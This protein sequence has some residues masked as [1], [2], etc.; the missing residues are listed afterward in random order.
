MTVHLATGSYQPAPPCHT[1]NIELITG[2]EGGGLYF[3]GISRGVKTDGYAVI[4]LTGLEPLPTSQVK[5]MND[6]GSQAFSLALAEAQRQFVAPLPWLRL[7]IKDYG[8]PVQNRKFWLAL[9]RDILA[10]ITHGTK[11]VVFCQGGHGRTGMVA[12]ILCYLL[13]PAAIG[14]DPV[15]WVR[16]RYCQ[17]AVETER[18][19]EY[20]HKVLKLPKPDTSQYKYKSSAVV[21]YGWW[22]NDLLDAGATD[23]LISQQDAVDTHDLDMIE[24]ELYKLFFWHKR[25]ADHVLVK[26]A[27]DGSELKLVGT[28]GKFDYVTDTGEIVFRNSLMSETAEHFKQEG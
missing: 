14:S 3:G 20:V 27:S 12:A 2:N 10:M 9:N 6:E 19:H 25:E 18:Q 13:N 21:T 1:G 16:E 4:D 22:K 11:V 26:K 23:E 28:K 24:S 5:A 8:I 17:S 7:P 15:T